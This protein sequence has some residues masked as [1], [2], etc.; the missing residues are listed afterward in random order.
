M[1]AEGVVEETVDVIALIEGNGAAGDSDV[2]LAAGRRLGPRTEGRVLGGD[3]DVHVAVGAVLA[4]RERCRVEAG[5][6]D[7]DVVADGG[8]RGGS[9]DEEAADS[10]HISLLDRAALGHL[11]ALGGLFAGDGGADLA[12]VLVVDAEAELE[13]IEVS[14]RLIVGG[15]SRRALSGDGGRAL[16]RGALGRGSRGDGS[17]SSGGRRSGLVLL[18]GAAGQHEKRREREEGGQREKGEAFH[19]GQIV[20]QWEAYPLQ[21]TVKKRRPKSYLPGRR[22][23]FA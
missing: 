12:P 20:A 16:R 7:L 23:R 17:A 14:G 1:V 6:D 11:T 8:V 19:S 2:A 22:R 3:G 15:G 21:P 5:G 13:E 9:S 4:Q 18:V 10:L